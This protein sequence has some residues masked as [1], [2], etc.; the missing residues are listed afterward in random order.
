MVNSTESKGTDVA[1][2]AGGRVWATLLKWQMSF[3]GLQNKR[4]QSQVWWGR[5]VIP[6]HSPMKELTHG[7]SE[8]FAM[9][10]IEP[11]PVH[12]PNSISRGGRYLAPRERT[13]QKLTPGRL[14]LTSEVTEPNRMN[15]G[16]APSRFTV[17]WILRLDIQAGSGLGPLR[18]LSFT[19]RC[20][21]PGSSLCVSWGHCSAVSGPTP[22]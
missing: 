15:R 22:L 9:Q 18:Q 13:L 20:V 5:P 11:I 16:R 4:P 7:T 10:T 21:L 2:S 12:R 14:V 19:R 1:A 8:A 6:A 17:S 3:L